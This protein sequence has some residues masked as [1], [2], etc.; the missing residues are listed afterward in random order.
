MRWTRWVTPLLTAALG[1]LCLCAAG[2]VWR[3][4]PIAVEW[5]VALPEL[6]FTLALRVDGLSALFLVLVAVLPT[7]SAGA[8]AADSQ[9]WRFGAP[10][11]VLTAAIATVVVA[12]DWVLFL[13]AWEVMT[14]ASYLLMLNNWRSARTARAGWVYL[15]TTHVTG[16]A[17]LVG[18]T[19]LSLAGG[20]YSFADAAAGLASLEPATAHLIIGLF[21]LGFATK[22]AIWPLSFWLPE[23]Y[24]NAPAPA[25][26]IFSGLMAKMGVYGLIRLFFFLAPAPTLAWG[27]ALATFGAAAMLVGNLRALSEQEAGRLVAQSSIGQI[28]YVI[29]SLG[30]AAA[31]ADRA[32]A[33][34]TLAFAAALYHLVNHSAFKALLF[35]TVGTIRRRTGTQDLRRLGGLVQAMPGVAFLTLTGA[36]A[37]AGTPPLNGFVSKW[38]IYRAAIFGGNEIPLLAVYGVLAIFL[39]TVSLAAY[40]KYF[41]TAFLGPV[42]AAEPAPGPEPA[43]AWAPQA[44]LGM[45]CLAL[46]LFPRPVVAGALAALS[47]SAL[48]PGATA[49]GILGG[50]VGGAAYQPLMVLLALA[51]TFGLVAALRRMAPA[52]VRPAPGPWLCG[53]AELLPGE[54]RYGSSQLFVPLLERFALLFR[55]WWEPG[56]GAP[57]WGRR[58][59]DLDG[60]LLSPLAAGWLALCRLASGLHQG[61]VQ[62][63]LAWQVL[64][65]ALLVL[66]LLGLERGRGL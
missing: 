51:L 18:A 17:I 36:L 59:L 56:L 10:L 5:A 1:C 19:A 54:S 6:P 40:L 35:L 44:L 4:G 9:D 37:I 53:E 50:T 26:A 65:V 27:M 52:E 14:L 22:A 57:A 20:S 58:A 66:I 63:Y 38:L 43:A 11:L 39:S 30:M 25:A 8:A 3:S 16:G 21:A 31:L 64:T 48:S 7:L 13:F 33:L 46:G 12:A 47:G 42:G 34:A 32:P 2:A 24:S 62:R 23:A 15:I 61:R 55:P 41:G 49:A 28:G 29:F 45:A 60:W